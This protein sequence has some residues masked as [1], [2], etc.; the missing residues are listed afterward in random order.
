MAVFIAID[1]PLDERLAV[2][3]FNERALS[4]R[5]QRRD[6]QGDGLFAAEGDLVVERALGAGCVAVTALVDAANPPEVADRLGDDVVVY[7]A[8]ERVR[9]AA[10]RLGAPS[11]IIAIFRRPPRTTVEALATSTQRLVLAEAVDN[12]VNIG[13]IIRNAAGLGWHGLITDA[14]SAD[15][16]ARRSLRVSMGHAVVFPHARSTDVAASVRSL[17]AAG[18]VV[19]ALTPAADAVDL[20]DVVA[21]DLP[22][23]IVLCLGSERSG[24]SPEVQHAA[25][26]RLRIPMAAGIDSLNVAAAS[27][28]ACWAL[29]P[30][31]LATPTTERL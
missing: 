6:D 4:N 12:P 21:G 1:D 20:A 24:L 2:F 28:I 7:A 14:T 23:R 13:S 8:G 31:T 25:S 9:A 11:P 16:L 17:V 29:R 26:L 18:F 30:A 5:V 3:R 22:E 19:A 15:P 10:T 27:A